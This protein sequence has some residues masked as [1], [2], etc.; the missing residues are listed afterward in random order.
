MHRTGHRLPEEA[1]HL[2]RV[3]YALDYFGFDEDRL[4]YGGVSLPDPQG[5]RI[6]P[7]T[8]WEATASRP[9]PG[10]DGRAWAALSARPC[11]P[12]SGYA[13]T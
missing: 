9:I 4:G 12:A 5:G 1:I 2:L 8:G 13:W 10:R 3:S 11:L 7:R 6:S